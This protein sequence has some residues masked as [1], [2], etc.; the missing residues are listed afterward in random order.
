MHDSLKQRIRQLGLELPEPSQPAA[1]YLN[2]VRSQN[3][4]FISGQIPCNRAAR[5]CSGG[6]AK[7]SRRNRAPRLPSW[8]H[9]AC[10]PNWG[11]P[12]R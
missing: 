5:S 11:G 9:W 12:G 8:P 7:A 4:L 1:N 2:Q 6:L 3:L 10:W